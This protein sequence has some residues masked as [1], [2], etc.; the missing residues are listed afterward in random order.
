MASKSEQIKTLYRHD[1]ASFIPFAFR[2]LH[3]GLPYLQNWHIEVMADYLARCARGEIKRL[4]INVPPRSLKSLC[5][6]IA[7]PAWLLGKYPDMEILYAHC[8]PDLLEELEEKT[9]MLMQSSRYQSLFPAAAIMKSRKDILLS[10]GGSRKAVTTSNDLT[11]RGAGMVII[12]DALSASHAK[13]KAS[14]DKVNKWYDANIYQRL[15]NKSDAVIIVVMQRL[16][17]DD[18]TGHL[19]RKGEDWSVLSLP[20]IAA[21][22]ERWELSNGGVYVRKKGEALHSEMESREQLMECLHT[23]GAFNFAMQYQQA[24]YVPTGNASGYCNGFVPLN[25]DR[26]RPGGFLK[27]PETTIMLSEIFGA[28]QNP[29]LVTPEH[30]HTNEEWE[31]LLIAQQ[32]RLIAEADRDMAPTP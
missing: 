12:D 24:T 30:S 7:F 11:G 3:P 29:L 9:L 2:E 22:D 6:S 23:V 13:D 4:I 16:H 19:L 26:K 10:H 27:I 18:L 8:S 1:F 5:A 32:R 20:A 21:E 14:R 25:K 28:G 15:N 17:P 31:A